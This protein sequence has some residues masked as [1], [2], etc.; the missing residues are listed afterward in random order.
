MN[1]LFVTGTDTG[2]G[3]TF[4]T[5]G[6]ARRAREL[7]K[8]VFAFKPVETG[9]TLVEGRLVG[10]DQEALCKAAGNWQRDALR[11]VYQFARPVAP[12]IAAQEQG[13]SIDVDSIVRVFKLGSQDVGLS[14]VE[15]AGGWRVPVTLGLDMGGLAKR[16]GLPV[17]L[18][19]RAGLGTINHC[20]LSI[21]AILRDGCSLR[22]VVLS[23]KPQD[24]IALVEGN[25]K[26]IGRRWG[27]EVIV[28]T[29]K[30]RTLDRLC[31]T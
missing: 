14:L 31:S 2:V 22:A 4:V 11:G 30:D 3:K 29:G 13:A 1:G 8:R 21:E 7:G 18:V 26:E 6:I 24:E 20:L 27:G 12:L 17:V 23:R 9:C 10:D 28:T 16:I 15:G 19:G 5:V 25:A